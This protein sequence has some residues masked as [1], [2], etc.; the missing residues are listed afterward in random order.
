MIE[1]DLSNRAPSMWASDDI[2]AMASAAGGNMFG[3]MSAELSIAAGAYSATGQTGLWT[4]PEDHD[5]TP[6]QS[7]FYTADDGY[8]NCV[9]LTC[10]IGLF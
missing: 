5:L 8:G 9:A 3:N 2:R 10:D 1:F 6:I 4:V 7:A